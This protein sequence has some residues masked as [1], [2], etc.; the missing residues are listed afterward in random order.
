MKLRKEMEH[1]AVQSMPLEE[2][3]LL[4]QELADGINMLIF[5]FNKKT[6]CKV[7]AFQPDLIQVSDNMPAVTCFYPLVKI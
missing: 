2:V 7:Y 6:G 5:E 4:Q 3:R 1:D